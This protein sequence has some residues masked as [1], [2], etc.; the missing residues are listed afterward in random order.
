M[1]TENIATAIAMYEAI[2]E[3]LTPIT[4]PDLVLRKL[5]LIHDNN[6]AINT[7]KA[8]GAAAGIIGNEKH[9]PA[10][11]MTHIWGQPIES[12]IP[13][14]EAAKATEADAATLKAQVKSLYD[15]FPEMSNEDILTKEELLIRGVAK[16]AMYGSWQTGTID[17][18]FIDGV[19][20]NIA[21]IKAGKL[22]PPKSKR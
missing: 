18:A 3:F 22:S 9:D 12:R 15:S 14:S 17:G 10:K 6:R 21:Q 16:V 19:K 11:P 4:T 5:R 13:A 2:N 8:A 20:D 1:M 7:L